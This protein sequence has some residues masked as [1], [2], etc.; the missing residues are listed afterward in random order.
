MNFNI[1]WSSA[2]EEVD[3]YK[4]QRDI[5]YVNERIQKARKLF[6]EAE[7][8]TNW[9][10][11]EEK[12]F[13]AS[14]RYY[15]AINFLK[16]DVF[17]SREKL[18]NH[19]Y[20]EYFVWLE[21]WSEIFNVDKKIDIYK[22]ILI[23]L[24]KWVVEMCKTEEWQKLQNSEELLTKFEGILK[25]LWYKDES[26]KTPEEKL[27]DKINFYANSWDLRVDGSNYPYE[28]KE[29]RQEN[30]CLLACN[31][32]KEAL[33]IFQKNPNLKED[34][35]KYFVILKRW[36]KI[37]QTWKNDLKVLNEYRLYAT[38]IYEEAIEFCK[39]N[40]EEYGEYLSLFEKTISAL[41]PKE[42]PK[43]GTLEKEV[44]AA[45]YW[46]NYRVK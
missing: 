34:T 1:P 29:F 23:D 43:Y 33:E 6:K 36:S 17:Y 14:C 5:D 20:D 7:S 28:E 30:W 38:K 42:H 21:E 27:W 32:Y 11:K 9:K 18:R 12:Y 45:L 26:L 22:D 10:E 40:K 41:S 35:D 2:S 37:L 8:S 13:S 19:F 25:W 16:D 3:K 46:G 31:D 44:A 4:L 24:C 39:K 15:D